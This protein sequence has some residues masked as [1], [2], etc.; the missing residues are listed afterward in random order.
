M[1][2]ADIE[3]S[4]YKFCYEQFELPLGIKIFESVYYVDFT[5][6]DQWIVI[7]SLSH[8]TTSIPTAHF[9][10]H[11]SLKSGLLN[12]KVALNRL[13]DTVTQLINPGTRIDVYS[14]ST[15]LLLGEMEV[16]DTSL[17]PQ[18]DHS[19]GGGYRSLSVS[20]VYAGEVYN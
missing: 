6:Y 7:D 11:L 8:T 10:L 13:C 16:G 5:S 17:T 3:S 4:L 9:F 15:G 2:I 12:S 20:I 18:L 1:K 14:D 19:G